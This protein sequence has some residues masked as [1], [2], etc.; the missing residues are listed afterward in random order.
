M[1]KGKS[2]LMYFVLIMSVVFGSMVQADSSDTGSEQKLQAEDFINMDELYGWATIGGYG[3]D[4]TT[5]GGTV[6]P[7]VVSTA[8]EL[9][10]YGTDNV[11]RVIVIDGTIELRGYL[12]VGCNKTIVG[13]DKDATVIG[14][15]IIKDK[16]N[17]IISNLNIKGAWPA[18]KPE[19]G[20]EVSNSHHIWLNHLNIWDAPDGNLDIKL[21]SDYITVSWCKFWYTNEAHEHRL[22]NLISS[23]TGNDT[24]DMEKLHVT[25]HHNWFADL[26]AERQPRLLY[27]QG[28]IYNNYYTSK[29]C[30]YC[31]GVGC[32][33]AA[34]VENNYFDEV[35]NPH[36]FFYSDVYPAHITARGNEYNNTTG[37]KDTGFVKGSAR[38]NINAFDSTP[39]SYY[40]DDA[41]EIPDIVTEYA[42]PRDVLLEKDYI[43]DGDIV[44]SGT[45]SEMEPYPIVTQSP[46]VY[47]NPVTYDK[48]TDTYTYHGQNKNGTNGGIDIVNPFSGMDLSETP[49]YSSDGTPVWEN[50]VTLAYWIYLPANAGDTPVFNF[51]LLN[52]RQMDEDDTN[53]YNLCKD[54]SEE[55]KAYSLGTASTYYSQSGKPLTV[56]SGAGR[57]AYC[58]PDY[59]KEGCYAISSTQ[60]TIP[61]YPEGADPNDLTQYV[62]LKYLGEAKYD[63]YSA[64]YD[65]ENGENSKIEEVLVNGSLSLY[66]SGTVGYCRDNKTGQSI[67]PNLDSYG[68]VTQ[69]DAGSEFSYWGNGAR[70]MM[71]GNI[72]TPTM[73]KKGEWHYVVTV[74]QNDWIQTYMDGIKLTTDYLNY[75]GNTLD[76]SEEYFDYIN[77]KSYSF[78]RGYGPRIRYRTKAADSK[79]KYCRTMLDMITDEN[80]VLTIGGTG[81]SA[82]IFSQEYIRT[83]ADIKVR[84]VTAYPIAVEENCIGTD[85]VL[86]YV[87]GYS[88]QGQELVELEPDPTPQPTERPTETPTTTPTDTPIPYRMGDV[89]MNGIVDAA[90]ALLVLK[91]AA[92]LIGLNDEQ[93]LLA[94]IETDDNVDAAD[95]LKILKIAAKIEM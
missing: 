27:G 4:T 12:Y 89:D 56:L 67:N 44:P 36:Q 80:T 32:Y 85:D 46:Y 9:Q 22:S 16:N 60:G 41:K 30:T 71:Y 58:N 55:K 48:N 11:P 42:G 5:G 63:G 1:R 35:N 13:M 47:D 31:I 62:Y 64:K 75:F 14:D 39:Y 24:T 57:Y 84:N 10:S 59:P 15:F 86:S 18:T 26:I 28:H 66:A 92:K 81:C 50:G 40:L 70:W 33:A 3:V 37:S 49:G 78:N 95:A 94:D 53:L 25:Y 74:I 52:S 69:I 73:K 7:V 76:E 72:D 79:Y 29:G 20:I 19:D 77:A 34:L 88:I 61:A 38:I 54:Y 65:E 91:D 51:N 23:G 87:G 2:L 82:S 6:T 90:D 93:V 43:S 17:V 45:S 68:N 21:G 83:G 8:D